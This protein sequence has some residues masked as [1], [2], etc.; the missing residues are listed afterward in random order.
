MLEVC[1]RMQ[2]H[3]YCRVLNANLSVSN[4]KVIDFVS[5]STLIELVLDE[6]IFC[7]KS[8]VKSSYD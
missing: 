2:Q 7:M 1:A 3:H 6:N 4:V 8:L 5:L